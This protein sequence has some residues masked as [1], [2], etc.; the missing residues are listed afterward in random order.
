MEIDR[1]WLASLR[2]RVELIKTA[3]AAVDLFSTGLE[4]DIEGFNGLVDSWLLADK[5][6]PSME[7]ISLLLDIVESFVGVKDGM[8]RNS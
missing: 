4:P 8:G 6:R 2:F 1:Q 3:E 7:E 5:H